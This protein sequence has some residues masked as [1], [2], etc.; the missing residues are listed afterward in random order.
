[1]TWTRIFIPLGIDTEKVM[2]ENPHLQIRWSAGNRH[3][4]ISR[5]WGRTPTEKK[6]TR[7]GFTA[8][9]TNPRASGL[10]WNIKGKGV[11]LC[12]RCMGRP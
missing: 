6:C 1:M 5:R 7:C 8:I 12:P 10:G 3:F 9:L 2:A 4:D 11:K